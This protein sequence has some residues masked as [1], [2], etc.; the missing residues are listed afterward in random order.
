MSCLRQ[1][2]EGELSFT[3][4]LSPS[5]AKSFR[6]LDARH[7][8]A[9]NCYC[10]CRAN[11]LIHNTVEAVCDSVCVCVQAQNSVARTAKEEEEEEEVGCLIYQQ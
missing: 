9:L 3:A 1:R 8:T 5:F 7:W 2:G 10:F 6:K 11:N 4:I